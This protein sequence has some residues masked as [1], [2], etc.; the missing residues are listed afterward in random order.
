MT[1]TLET[2]KCALETT[3]RTP[4]GFAPVAPM[5]SLCKCCGASAPLFCVADFHRNC[6]GL[7]GGAFALSGIPIYYFRCPACEFLFTT[8]FDEWTAQD[9]ADYVY[10]DEY[11]LVDPDFAHARPRNNAQMIA[12]TFAGSKDLRLL[13]YGGGNGRLAEFLRAEGF[14]DVQTYDPFVPAHAQRPLGAYDCIVSFEV[15]EHSPRPRET[16]E[17]IQSLRAKDGLVLFSTLAQPGDI[18]QQ[19]AGWWYVGPRNGHVS[20]HS[21]QSLRVLAEEWKLQIGSFGDNLHLLFGTLPSWAAHLVAGEK[22]E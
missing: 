9:F 5:Q 15:M 21:H 22:K 19:G 18:E 3:K 13:D 2:T 12:Q 8:A 7:Q 4:A 17:D 11:A 14:L 10:N 20:L 6:A 16:W 1:P